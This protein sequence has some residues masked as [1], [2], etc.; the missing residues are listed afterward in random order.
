[1]A[2]YTDTSRSGIGVPFVSDVAHTYTHPSVSRTESPMSVRHTRRYLVFH[3]ESHSL[4]RAETRYTPFAE[5]PSSSRMSRGVVIFSL[6]R[7]GSLNVLIWAS[8]AMSCVSSESPPP[9]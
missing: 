7:F 1:M 5:T 4:S 9:P 2:P 8:P 6:R 3:D